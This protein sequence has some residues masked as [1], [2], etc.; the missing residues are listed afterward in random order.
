MKRN[1][2]R[3]ASKSLRGQLADS[4][5]ALTYMAHMSGKPI[6][7]QRTEIA[8]KKERVKSAIPS[9]S[10]EQRAFVIWWRSQYPK[11]RIFAIP[12]GGSRDQITG[13]ILK[14][15][16]VEPGVPDL[17]VPLLRLWIEMKRIK[18]S[19]ISDEQK[20]WARYLLIECG[21]FHFFAYG[22]DDAIAQTKLFMKYH[23]QQTFS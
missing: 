18:R 6:M 2:L 7:H 11:I 15:E 1:I 22:C 13:A 4:D 16:G 17:Y 21:D 10:Q 5:K 9:E 20:E 14:A 12:N 8:P 19:T 3:G 23:A